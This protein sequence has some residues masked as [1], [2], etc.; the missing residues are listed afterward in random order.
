MLLLFSRW[1]VFSTNEGLEKSEAQLGKGARVTVR[2][3]G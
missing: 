2:E 3:L 1:D